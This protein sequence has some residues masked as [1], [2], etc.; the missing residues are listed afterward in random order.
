MR[1]DPRISSATQNQVFETA[2]RLGYTPSGP[3]AALAT[4]RTPNVGVVIPTLR[5]QSYAEALEGAFEAALAANYGL[6]LFIVSEATP[7]PTALK[8]AGGR[9]D[10]LLI[11]ELVSVAGTPRPSADL[12]LRFA[13]RRKG[14]GKHEKERLAAELSNVCGH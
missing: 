6:C 7:W 13:D 8:T 2:E 11:V 1:N 14:A 12:V 10:A 4:G 9:V 5:Q 3:A